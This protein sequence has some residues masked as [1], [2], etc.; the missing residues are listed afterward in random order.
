METEFTPASGKQGPSQQKQQALSLS[1][2]CLQKLNG[3]MELEDNE[4][5]LCVAGMRLRDMYT[6]TLI[7][8]F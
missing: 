3:K 8:D 4:V 6:Q 2:Y 7:K 1:T 5:S